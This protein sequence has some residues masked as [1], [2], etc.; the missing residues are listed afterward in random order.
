F[1][2]RLRPLSGACHVAPPLDPACL[3]GDRAGRTTGPVRL[4]P[5]AGAPGGPA[6]GAG[7]LGGPHPVRLAAARRPRLPFGRAGGS[8]RSPPVGGAGGSGRSPP[9][10]GMQGYAQGSSPG[11]VASTRAGLV[12]EA[13]LSSHRSGSSLTGSARLNVRVAP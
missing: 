13:P 12:S 1:R 8:G 5:G 4:P 2:L 6:T 3:S 11:G 9:V 10:P 7:R